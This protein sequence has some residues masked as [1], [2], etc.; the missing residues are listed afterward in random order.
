[1]VTTCTPAPACDTDS[2]PKPVPKRLS[3]MQVKRAMRA[4]CETF[5]VS[6]SKVEEGVQTGDLQ[7]SDCAKASGVGLQS[8]SDFVQ[9]NKDVS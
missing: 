8:I 1:M 4:G 3:A 7:E 6:I 9:A 5:L 2:T